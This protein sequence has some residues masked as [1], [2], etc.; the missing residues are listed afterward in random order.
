MAHYDL[1]A[2]VQRDICRR[3]AADVEA[4]AHPAESVLELGA[5]TG[6]LTRHLRRIYPAAKLTVN[7]LTPKAAKYLDPLLQGA[8][9]DYLWGDAETTPFPA[10]Y[11]LVASSSTMQWFDAPGAFIAKCAAHTL[12]GGVLA[13]STFGPD[14]FREI[15]A[16]AGRGLEYYD[17]DQIGEMLK[18]SEYELL[19]MNEFRTELRFDAPADVLRHI[20]A[21]GV[22]GTGYFC[23]TAGRLREF[24]A[25]YR[26]DFSTPEGVTLTYHPIIVTA[27]RKI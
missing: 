22:S 12:P 17:A 20:K 5:G 23:W 16:A 25:R 10:R 27:K 24:D 15:R 14:N 4:A 6:F 1:Q 18:N 26:R 19:T 13:L 7:D 9:Y 8:T 2:E 3:L 21:T 11:D